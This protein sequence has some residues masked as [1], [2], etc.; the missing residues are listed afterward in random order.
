MNNKGFFW[1]SAGLFSVLAT[2]INAA[3]GIPFGPGTLFP[4]IV[5]SEE[6]NDNLFLQGSNEFDTWITYLTPRL[7]YELEGDIRKFTFEGGIDH[8]TYQNSSDDNYL[9]WDLKAT[10]E[11]VPTA[12]LGVTFTAGFLTGHDSRGSDDSEGAAATAFQDPDEFET[13][14]FSASLRYGLEDMYAPN[15]TVSYNFADTQYLNNRA[16]TADSDIEEASLNAELSMMVMPNT[17]L[18]LDARYSELDYDSVTADDNS[19]TNLLVGVSWDATYQTTGTLKIGFQEKDYDNSPARDGISWDVSIDWKPLS[20]STVTLTTTQDFSD[21]AGIVNVANTTINT[22]HNVLWGHD[23]TDF[24]T[25]RISYSLSEGEYLG[26]TRFDETQTWSVGVDYKVLRWLSLSGDV[27]SA[28]K[29]S[30]TA[31]LS[32]D[33]NIYGISANIAL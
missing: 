12:R 3:D 7:A 25:S 33:N 29:T 20:Y 27:S 19:Y 5:V 22:N 9:D 8:G 26:T 11:F 1:I 17:K 13:T 15:L 23:W 24:L 30:N 14:D 18:V 4:S 2:P 21:S 10:A 32:Y 31:D 6:Y 28:A 16:R